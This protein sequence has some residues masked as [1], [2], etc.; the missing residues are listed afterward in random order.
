VRERKSVRR[1]LLMMPHGLDLSLGDL[2]VALDVWTPV[3]KAG[4]LRS[5][6]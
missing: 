2:T 3:L 5:V 6:A 4:K 1:Y